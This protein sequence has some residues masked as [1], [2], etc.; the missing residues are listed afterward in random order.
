MG[1]VHEAVEDG[2]GECRVADDVVPLLDGKLAGD[3]RRADAVSVFEDFEQVVTVLGAERSEP[4]V[5][6]HED[7]GLGERRKQLRVASVGAGD[8]QRAEQP[9]QA[10]VEG[11][12]AVAAGAVGERASDPALADAGRPA[13]QD[14]EMLSDPAPVG[15]RE[16]ERL[17]EAAAV[18]EVDVLDAGVVLEP[19]ATQPVRELSGVAFGELAVDE[20]SSRAARRGPW[21]SRRIVAAGACRRSDESA[22][23]ESF[24]G[25]W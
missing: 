2:V 25:H 8:G 1:I 12:V 10:Q 14:V 6:E 18:P 20:Q 22:W 7:L 3:D 21:P 4:P 19:G 24:P 15:E 23:S 17:V 16:D 5:V 9:G 11:A 13:D